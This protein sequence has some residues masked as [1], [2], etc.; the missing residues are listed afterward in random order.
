MADVVDF[1]C[2]LTLS[3][4]ALNQRS[5]T[6]L[7]GKE[8]AYTQHHQTGEGG[9]QN[10]QGRLLSSSTHSRQRCSFGG[11]GQKPVH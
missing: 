10:P 9:H 7:Q 6:T 8:G 2:S 4:R 11:H 5:P 3:P 1:E